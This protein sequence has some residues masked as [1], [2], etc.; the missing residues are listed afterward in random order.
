MLDNIEGFAKH[1]PGVVLQNFFAIHNLGTPPEMC[2]LLNTVA[3]ELLTKKRYLV[4]KYLSFII[5]I[6][7]KAFS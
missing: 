7:F 1:F 5:T 6:G 3:R 2:F 4:K